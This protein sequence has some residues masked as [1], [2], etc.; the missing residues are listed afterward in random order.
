MIGRALAL[1]V[2]LAAAAATAQA[3][4]MRL[5]CEGVRTDYNDGRD[6]AQ[7]YSIQR[8]WSRRLRID[9][10]ARTWC[11]EPCA[12]TFPVLSMRGRQ[13][14]LGGSYT[15]EAATLDLAS[16]RYREPNWG[17]PGVRGRCVAA[18]ARRR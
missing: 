18:D 16:G 15:D 1:S 11:E 2:L 12:Q 14:S 17:R 7:W 6:V 10:G 5:V 8:P 13:V 4:P 3:E 9:T